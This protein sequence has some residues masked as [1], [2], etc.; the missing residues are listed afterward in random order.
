MA[1]PARRPTRPSAPARPPRAVPASG[2]LTTAEAAALLHVHPKQVYRLFAR[3][4]PHRRVGDEWRYDRD[5]LLAW[6]GGSPRAAVF[7]SVPPSVV[8]SNGDVAVG[9][10]LALATSETGPV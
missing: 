4:L 2:L 7:A 8:A 9:L 3:G 10:L 1:Q 6:S 5:E